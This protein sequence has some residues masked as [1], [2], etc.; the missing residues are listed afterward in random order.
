MK[1]AATSGNLH[2]PADTYI[3]III[4]NIIPQSPVWFRAWLTEGRKLIQF[5]IKFVSI[6]FK[7]GHF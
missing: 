5:N 4:Y 7:I 2:G 3:I 6:I 1:P